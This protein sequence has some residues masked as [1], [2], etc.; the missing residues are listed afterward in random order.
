MEPL[1]LALRRELVIAV[2]AKLVE[3]ALA[4]TFPPVKVLVFARSVEDAAVMV[5][6]AVPLKPTLLMFLDVWSAV[7]VPA[8]PEMEPVMVFAKMLLPPK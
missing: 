4:K 3:V 7:A 2:I 8:F 5:M 1:P 6:S